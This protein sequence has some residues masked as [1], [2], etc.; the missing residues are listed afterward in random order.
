MELI[1]DLA[2]FGVPVLLFSGGEPLMRSDLIEL[3]AHAVGNGLRT[4]ISTN[5]TLITHEKAA[6]LKAAGVSYA[7]ISLDG[8]Q[9]VNDHF[10]GVTGA[11]EKA[12]AGIRHC[13]QAGLKVGVRF[14]I[15]KM[16]ADQVPGI[17]DLVEELDIERICFYHLVYSGRGSELID[18]DL[19][20]DETR[21]I[22]DLIID[23]T[24]DFHER[25]LK[26][27]V[28]TVDN[29]VDGAYLYLRMLR[30]GNPRAPEVLELLKMNGGNSSGEG[31]GCV[32]WDGQVYADQFWRQHSFGTVLSRPFSKI[33]SDLGNPL[34][35][36]LKTKKKQVKGR[37]ARCRWLDICGGNFRARAE[38]VSGDIW[39]EDPACYLTDQEIERA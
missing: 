4:V 14:T 18:H 15:N 9:P 12:V 13:Q 8:L 34:M 28:L 7:G 33:W 5:G 11:F 39:A 17:F 32:S 16:N 22:V 27:E 24:K 38:A 20:H 6:E 23:R 29:H 2:G 1:D 31:I 37:C 35:A 25:G 21:K 30:E 26:K 10:R 36:Q 3:A 19:T